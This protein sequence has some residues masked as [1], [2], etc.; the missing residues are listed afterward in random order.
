MS[1]GV[2][3]CGDY[4]ILKQCARCASPWHPQGAARGDLRHRLFVSRFP[5][6]V[7]SYGLHTI[8]GR[9]PAVATG[10]QRSP[11]PSF[12][13]A[14]SRATATPSRSGATTLI[15]ML[16]RNVDMQGVAVQQPDL[17]ADQGAV[18]AHLG[19]GLKVAKSTPIGSHGPAPS[20]RSS[21]RSAPMRDLRGAHHRHAIPSTWRPCC[22]RRPC[23]TPGSSLRGDLPEL[24][25]LSTTA[26]LS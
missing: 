10:A 13:L 8:H 9:A 14:R 11:I 21:W 20:I 17:R 23:T 22:W 12:R 5:Y 3:G 16:R 7:N 18:F 1:A 26:L 6:Y 19:A 2:P 4:S 24:R 15:H 25:D